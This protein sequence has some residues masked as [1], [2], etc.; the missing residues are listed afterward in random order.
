MFDVSVREF[1]AVL[2]V[3]IVCIRN[4][5]ICK[6]I[7]LLCTHVYLYIFSTLHPRVNI[8]SLLYPLPKYSKS[9]NM[10]TPFPISNPFPNTP[11]NKQHP[12]SCHFPSSSLHFPLDNLLNT[13]TPHLF[14]IPSQTRQN[15][16][17]IDIDPLF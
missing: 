3:F 11:K 8:P 1:F 13:P 15:F 16:T 12:E 7:P 6:L 5:A 14:L 9:L 17:H 10:S 2:N 4:T